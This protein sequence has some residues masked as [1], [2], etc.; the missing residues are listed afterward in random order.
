MAY[1]ILEQYFIF[2]NIMKSPHSCGMVYRK[3]SLTVYKLYNVF[4]WCGISNIEAIKHYPYLMNLELQNNNI[5][6]ISVLGNM[7]YLV[8][9][10]LS[11]NKLVE[12]LKIDP[13]PYNLQLLDLSRNQITNISDLS[14][15]K[16]I[17][18]LVN[19]YYSSE[20]S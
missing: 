11:G 5:T 14:A 6:D 13:P 18:K 4:K 9:I 7:R 12:N 2:L 15:L 10:D 20:E 17:T 19:N 8:Q 16:F 1:P 3:L